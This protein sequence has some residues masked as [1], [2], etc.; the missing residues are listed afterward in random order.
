MSDLRAAWDKFKADHDPHTA[1]EGTFRE[2]LVNIL[3]HVISGGPAQAPGP[4]DRIADALAVMVSLHQMSPLLQHLHGLG[5]RFAAQLEGLPPPAQALVMEFC[6]VIGVKLTAAPKVEEAPQRP[7]LEL[8]PQAGA[9]P[10]EQGAAAD[11]PP[12]APDVEMTAAPAEGEET[13]AE[14]EDDE[15]R[16]AREK[17]E[18]ERQQLQ[19]EESELKAAE[20]ALQEAE[21]KTSQR[22]R[23]RASVAPPPGEEPKN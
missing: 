4:L 7:M 3:N 9:A 2:G 22:R 21:G 23:Q 1:N 19:K 8:V 6:E 17:V 5:Q 14:V 15:L 18:A 16:L 12:A 10:I 11:A 20:A 13:P